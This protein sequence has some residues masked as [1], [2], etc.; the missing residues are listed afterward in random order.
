M[1]TPLAYDDRNM[2]MTAKDRT[3]LKPRLVKAHAELERMRD[4]G[5]QGFFDL[6]SDE[7]TVRA[8]ESLAKKI[9]AKFDHMVVIGIGGSDLGSR[10]IWHALG[11]SKMS[12]SFLSNPDPETLYHALAS[13]DW[14]RTAVN[15]ISKSG[16]TLETMAIFMAVRKRLIDVVGLEAHRA[17]VIATTEPS[18]A[19][20]LYQI[21]MTE[22]YVV[23][24]HPMNVGGRYSVLS[25][26]G[27]FPAAA[28]G[29]NVRK[30]LRGAAFVETDRRA[31]KFGSDPARFAA[32]QYLSMTKY[33]RDQHVLMPYADLLHEVGF[34]YR[35]LW[36]ESL[37]K[38]R[39]GVSV[40][41]TPIAA[42]G[43]ID[44]HS[45]IQLYNEGPDNKT[46]TFLEVET[47]RRALRVPKIWGDK[48]G[49]EYVG[50]LSFASILHAERAGTEHALK[51]NGRPSGTITIP[52]ISEESIGALFMFFETATAYMGELLK[53]NAFN[54][55]GVEAGKKEARRILEMKN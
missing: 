52:K 12:L 4:N 7:K 9:Q 55:P 30:I 44:Q 11:E 2:G 5:S 16:T 49:I 18:D 33:G 3:S 53:I 47:F 51:S 32:N 1:T 24:P 38:T 46:V 26:V 45:Q 27:L 10:T 14:S 39:D 28:S 42:F 31:K 54:Q 50:G 13:T 37:G 20:T 41:P 19:S 40:G 17:H 6:P 35:Q 48:Q 34:W 21:A 23:L 43:A 36:A 25:V 29:A 22:S 15:V 8:I